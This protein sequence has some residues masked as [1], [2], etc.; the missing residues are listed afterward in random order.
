VY[1]L[2]E[3]NSRSKLFGSKLTALGKS[4]VT[5]NVGKKLFFCH[6]SVKIAKDN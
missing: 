1:Q 2:L 6:T 3:A 5:T 4:W